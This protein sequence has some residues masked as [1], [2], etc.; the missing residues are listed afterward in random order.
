MKLKTCPKC[1]GRQVVMVRDKRS[2][3]GIKVPESCPK[4]KGTGKVQG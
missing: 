2:T 3:T 4:C 1:N